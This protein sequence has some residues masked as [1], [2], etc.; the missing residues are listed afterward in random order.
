MASLISVDASADDPLPDFRQQLAN[1]RTL[2]AWLR[3]AIA[4]AGLGFVV[5]HFGLFLRRFE[6]A[7]HVQVNPAAHGADPVLMGR[8]TGI[9]LV[10]LSAV[11]VIVGIAQY[12]LVARILARHH[13]LSPGPRWPASVTAVACGAAIIS[14]AIYLVAGT[15]TWP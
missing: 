15:P 7:A 8:D 5:A 9:A 3:T 4:L 6:S 10:G 13:D 12:Q 11:V 1:D 14:L 2:L